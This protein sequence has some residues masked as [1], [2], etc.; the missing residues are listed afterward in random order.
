M[1]DLATAFSGSGPALIFELARIFASKLNVVLGDSSNAEKII[2]QTF[3]GSAKLMSSS[4]LSF[5]ELRNNVTS[6]KGVTN[7]ALQVLETNQISRIFEE[8]FEAAMKKVNE[9]RGS[10]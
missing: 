6:A 8:A 9:M 2:T 7:E 5:E 3:L 1:L 10:N 4:E